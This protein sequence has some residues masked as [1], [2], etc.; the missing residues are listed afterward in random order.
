MRFAIARTLWQTLDAR[1][2]DMA[3][4]SHGQRLGPACAAPRR[5]APM[6]TRAISVSL[7]RLA[8]RVDAGFIQ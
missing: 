6:D 3:W 4:A 1:V 2:G 8:S 7:R 5:P